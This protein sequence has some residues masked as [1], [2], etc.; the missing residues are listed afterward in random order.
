MNFQNA[1]NLK[2]TNIGLSSCYGKSN[3]KPRFNKTAFKHVYAL[4][5]VGNLTVNEDNVQSKFSN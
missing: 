2:S 5:R 1:L 3:V 4:V